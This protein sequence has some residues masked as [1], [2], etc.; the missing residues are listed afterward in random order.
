MKSRGI[1]ILLLVLVLYLLSPAPASAASTPSYAAAQ[2]VLLLYDSLAKGTDMEGNVA[3]LQRLLAAYSTQVTLKDISG[4][5]QGDMAAY[6]GI[7]TVLNSAELEIKNGA[8]LQDAASFQGPVLHVGYRLPGRIARAMQVETGV[9]HG[10]GADLS[11]GGFSGVPQQ[12]E[13]MPYI[14]ASHAERSY[15]EWSFGAGSLQAPFAVSSG[16]YAYVPYL[17]QGEFSAMG[18]AYV[19]KDWLHSSIRPNT[20]LVLKEIYPFSDLELLEKTADELYR[21][22]IPFI[23]SIR[24]VFGNTD[25]PAMQRYLDAL[26][27]VQSRN[28]SIVVNAPA[29]R[30]PVM[31]SDR[32][33]RGKMSSFIDVLAEGGVAPL[34]MAAEGYWTYDKEYSAAGMGFFDSVVLYADEEARYMERSD[35]AMAFP[36]VLY[37]LPPELLQGI[38]RT[39]KAMPQLPVNAAV[40]IDLPEDESG[41]Q[42]MLQELDAEWYTFADYKQETHE[43]TTEITHIE[44]ADGVISVGGSRL[45][46]DYIPQPVAGDYEYQEQQATSFNRLFSVQNQLFIIVILIALLL[47][48]CLLTVGYRMYRRKYLK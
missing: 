38:S 28:G 22:G 9:W 10:T 29:V 16:V 45:N 17:K 3:E 30:P 7:I 5:R 19:L 2:R 20:Y 6:S 25:F 12:L 33:L 8:Y 18:M 24:P 1:L 4:Y 13:E 23:A 26:R 32:S 47:F 44:S 39:G 14:T 15:G 34:G 42:Q 48:G 46:V 21:R 36:S 27:T 40:T 43:V 41:L 31:S 35:T 11:V 37:S